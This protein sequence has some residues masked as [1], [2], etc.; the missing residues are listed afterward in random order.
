M[1]TTPDAGAEPADRW[2]LGEEPP[3]G[4][5]ALDQGAPRLL[6]TWTRLLPIGFAIVGT[7][8][9][10]GG[11]YLL[12]DHES[13]LWELLLERGW[14]QPVTLG[15]FFWGLGHLLRR[16]VVQ[17]GERRALEACRRLLWRGRLFRDEIP[18][19]LAALRRLHDSLAGP[20]LG[21]VLSYFRSHRPTRDEVL[22]VAT[23]EVDRAYDKV[24]HDYRAL[25]ATMWLLPLCGFLGTVVGM[26]EAIGTFDAVITTAGNDLSVLIPSVDG[27]AKAF[28]TTLLALVLVVP[29]KLLEVGMERRDQALLADVD[30]SVGAGLVRELDLA[31]L[32]QQT[33]EER[34]LDRYAETVERIEGSLKQIDRVLGSIAGQLGAMPDLSDTFDEVVGAA[35][36]ARQAMPRICAEIEALRVQSEQPIV[37]TR[38][39]RK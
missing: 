21:G 28:D 22:K 5:S 26:A 29:L 37:L 24:E 20:V 8:G 31:G 13:R 38:G 7:A 2:T 17:L 34:A 1:D 23:Q 9:A 16:F 19:R 25:S 6:G 35:R 18:E 32:A 15:L 14:T 36:A 12:A 11:T 30:K 27:L 4:A 3:A 33:P 10:I 39:P